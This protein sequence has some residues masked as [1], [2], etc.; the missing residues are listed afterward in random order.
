MALYVAEGPHGVRDY[1]TLDRVRAAEYYYEETGVWPEWVGRIED[2]EEVEGWEVSG[3]CAA[4]DQ[5]I[6]DDQDWT[7]TDSA[8]CHDECPEEGVDE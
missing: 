1:D 3:G 2:G 7:S 4:C 6:F 8:R 5:P